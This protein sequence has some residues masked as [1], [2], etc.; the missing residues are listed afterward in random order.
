MS[1]VVFTAILGASD[2]LKPAPAGAD[3]CVCFTDD[4]AHSL[5]PNGWEIAIWPAEAWLEPDARREAWRLRA[6]AHER[7]DCTTVVWVDASLTLTNLP[8]LLQDAAGHPLAGLPH[9][10]RH[11]CY[12]EGARL[13]QI[14]QSDA[15]A[16][17]AQLDAYRVAGFT[18]SS[19]TIACL[20]VRSNSK[21]VAAF[22]VAWAAEIARHC[23]DNT[24]LSLDYCAWKS[25]LAWHHLPGGRKVN[26]YAVH[27]HRDHKRRR[28]P[29]R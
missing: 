15:A 14:G 8:R 5:E 7:F 18:P 13:A 4:P 10:C 17:Q 25:G 6:L 9:D 28:R 3:R 1:I 26:P 12:E 22:N 23:G 19:L 16:V 29:Y 21:R 27:D 11:S 20:L 24:Q 2:S